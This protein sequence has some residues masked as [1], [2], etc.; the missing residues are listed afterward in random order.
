MQRNGFVTLSL[1]EYRARVPEHDVQVEAQRLL[2][3]YGWLWTHIPDSRIVQGDAGVPDIIA[4]HPSGAVVIAE[5]KRARKY[6]TAKQR[7]WLDAFA[8]NGHIKVFRCLRWDDLD[9]F[10]A[11]LRNPAMAPI[12]MFSPRQGHDP[13]GAA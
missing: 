1:A 8:A 10:A 11:Y 4:T 9:A 5:L 13:K 3:Q 7:Q 6:P 2:T 12:T